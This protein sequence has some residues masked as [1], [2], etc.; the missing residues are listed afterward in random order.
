MQE[1]KRGSKT[2]S[3][4]VFSQEEIQSDHNTSNLKELL[5]EI[6]REDEAR[7]DS[8]PGKEITLANLKRTLEFL[9]ALTGSAYNSIVE[10]LPYSLLKTAK[11]LYLTSREGG[12]HIFE[13]LALPDQVTNRSTF[14]FR[15]SG[16]APRNETKIGATL[17]LISQLEKGISEGR[18]KQFRTL[19]MSPFHLLKA[20]REENDEI[21]APIRA[22]PSDLQTE[23]TEAIAYLAKYVGS[24]R[25]PSAT[26]SDRVNEALYVRLLSLP[27]LHFVGEHQALEELAALDFQPQ[28]ADDAIR[29]LCQS[30]DEPDVEPYLAPYISIAGYP[31]FFDKHATALIKIVS[32]ITTLPVQKRDLAG[33]TD[34]I[35]KVLHLHVFSVHGRQPLDARL[36][37]VADVVAAMCT[38]AHQQKVKTPYPAHWQGKGT[39]DGDKK[40]N[41]LSQLEA[42]LS[43]EE[44]YEK[45]YVPQ[46]VNQLLLNRFNQFHAHMLGYEDRYHALRAFELARLAGYAQY[47]KLTNIDDM[48]VSVSEFND[49]SM[50][51]AYRC[52]QE[53]M[54]HKLL[55]IQD[56]RP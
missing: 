38:V 39:L 24:L 23:K 49:Q 29:A 48:I 41:A 26:A 14:E 54:A 34:Y 36:L 4:F 45:D 7:A 20:I 52:A 33:K 47:L 5:A 15:L 8:I 46:G 12:S 10:P 40:H 44:L 31:D 13:Y 1:A 43:I 16:K 22:L 6:N 21:L 35:Q 2:P 25:V 50:H 19:L 11:L 3:R 53:V 28:S 56:T 32:A 51:A 55:K 17:E 9:G 30:L 18:I 37:T 27:I 42:S